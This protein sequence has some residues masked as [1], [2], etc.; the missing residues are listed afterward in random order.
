[1]NA[2]GYSGGGEIYVGTDS[3]DHLTSASTASTVMVSP[4]A[5]VR[6]DATTRGDGGLVAIWSNQATRF[7]G[8]ASAQGGQH[9][10]NGGFIE[11]S[12]AKFLSINDSTTNVSAVAGDAGTWLL[13]PES[14]RISNVTA[15][16]DSNGSGDPG[17]VE[18]APQSDDTVTELDVALI[19]VGA[20]QWI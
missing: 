17:P 20:G 10:G 13:D 12:S 11:M 4:G 19:N 5:I 6:A 2:S 7:H 14:I 18:F 8:H 15:N 9:L 16:I 1:M 3:L